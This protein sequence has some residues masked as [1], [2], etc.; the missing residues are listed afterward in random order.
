MRLC[1]AKVISALA[2]TAT[3]TTTAV[4]ASTAAAEATTDSPMLVQI[5]TPGLRTAKHDTGV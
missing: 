4:A 1:T 2:A 3:S 5:R